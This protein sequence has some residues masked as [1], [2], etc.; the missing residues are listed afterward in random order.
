MPGGKLLRDHK[1]YRE[2]D[3]ITTSLKCPEE[4]ALPRPILQGINTYLLTSIFVFVGVPGKKP[5][6][7][8]R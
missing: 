7:A 1:R 6:R 5:H 8:G 3:L 2:N 4:L